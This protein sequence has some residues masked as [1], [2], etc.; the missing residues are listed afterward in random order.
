R[1]R[2]TRSKRDWSS[3]VC[4]SDL[5]F[6]GFVNAEISMGGLPAY[7]TNREAPLRSTDPENF[8]DS[9]AWLSAINEIIA[10]HQVTDGGGSVLMYQI[11][12]ASCRGRARVSVGD[13]AV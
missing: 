5:K 4:S 10:K 12:R 8:A 2:H 6:S 1:R 7:M 11:G 9:C 13:G 3:H